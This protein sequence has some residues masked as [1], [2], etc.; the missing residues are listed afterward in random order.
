M[1]MGRVASNNG[2]PTIIVMVIDSL[3]AELDK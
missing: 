1:E 2:N 3:T